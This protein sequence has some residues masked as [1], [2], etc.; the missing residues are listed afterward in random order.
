MQPPPPPPPPPPTNSSLTN[1]TVDESFDGASVILSFD[2]D[3][4][5]ATSNVQ[6]SQAGITSTNS[7]TYDAAADSFTISVSQG[8][9][10]YNQTFA[11]GD[12]D[13]G[14]SDASFRVYTVDNGGGDITDFV[15]L[16][17]GDPTFNLSY[18]TLG[19]WNSVTADAGR[20]VTI[21]TVVFGVETADS[22]MPATGSAT[23]T[24]L[25]VGQLDASN[26]I[27]S[28]AGDVQIDA[29]FASGA[30]TGAFT[31]MVK[32]NT[33]TGGL[34]AWRDFSATGSITAGTNLFSGTATTD[35]TLLTGAFD[36]GLFG[37]AATEVGGSFEL[38]GA[39]ETATGAFVGKQ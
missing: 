30:I 37:P 36:G 22:D 24:G 34:S 9:A 21:G 1:L 25:V 3:G 11:P 27:F 18:V 14:R 12:I 38:S 7:V 10:V 33:L 5:G 16:I 2:V 4:A 17:P 20:E 39:G 32:E 26:T 31:N 28:L 35:D 29:N 13:A 6:A 15:L 8:A 23:Y 19:L